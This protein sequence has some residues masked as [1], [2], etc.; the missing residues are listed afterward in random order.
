MKHA[1]NSLL[2]R[3]LSVV[4]ARNLPVSNKESIHKDFLD[5]TSHLG[6]RFILILRSYGTE[7]FPIGMGRDPVFVTHWI[8]P[9]STHGQRVECFLIDSST[10]NIEKITFEMAEKLAFELPSCDFNSIASVVSTVRSVLNEGKDANLWSSPFLPAPNFTQDEWP[11]WLEY[12]THSKNTVMQSYMR[13]AI[14]CATRILKA[15]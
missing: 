3:L 8:E 7:L 14:D 12:F 2:D 6:R 11:E 15:A 9:S 5:I 1:K 4:T 10:N 13:K